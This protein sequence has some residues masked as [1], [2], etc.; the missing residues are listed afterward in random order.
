MFQEQEYV[1][2]I[3]TWMLSAIHSKNQQKEFSDGNR[4]LMICSTMSPLELVN[5]PYVAFSSQ[6]GHG[7]GCLKQGTFL[8]LTHNHLFMTLFSKSGKCA[9]L[10]SFKLFSLRSSPREIV[11][12][13]FQT[14]LVEKLGLARLGE[15]LQW[16][17]TVIF[18]GWTILSI[19]LEL[20][21]W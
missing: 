10:R 6:C 3:G 13:V 11:V 1:C 2:G 14:L 7:Q 21:R 12:I 19:L 8:R 17:S 4:L 5:L 16:V 20:D 15:R 9:N 18:L